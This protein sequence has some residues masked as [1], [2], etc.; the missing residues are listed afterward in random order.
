VAHAGFIVHPT[1]RLRGGRAVV[2]LFGRLE[3]GEPF[4]VEDDRY[5]PYFFTHP[6]STRLLAGERDVEVEETEL[7]DMSGAPVVRVIAPVPPAVPRLR[8]K[9]EAGGARAFEADIRFPYRFL[10]DRGLRAAVAITGEPEP[11]ADSGLVRF[12]N[13]ELVPGSARPELS[14][15]SLDLE[16]APDASRIFSAALVG[17]GAVVTRDVPAHA[18]VAGS[19]ARVIGWVCAC[20]QR[21][22]DSTGHPAPATRERYAIDRE[23]SCT[24]C[25]RHYAFVGDEGA[26]HE[27]RGPAISQGATA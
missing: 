16:T 20:G 23:L 21:L 24:A 8:E 4:L 11:S 17:A 6:E 12:R 5:R 22:H 7:V 3:S 1:Y 26:L 25:G 14:V 13:P 2:Q 15:L 9:L 19:P 18:L 27:Q 10:I